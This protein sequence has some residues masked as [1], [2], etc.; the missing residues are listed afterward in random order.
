[1]FSSSIAHIR[2]L[3]II[4]YDTFLFTRTPFLWQVVQWLLHIKI[5]IIYTY[6][7]HTHTHIDIHCVGENKPSFFEFFFLTDFR[8][9]KLKPCW[10]SKRVSERYA[11]KSYRFSLLFSYEIR[12]KQNGFM[13]R[14][15][16]YGCKLKSTLKNQKEQYNYAS[17][18]LAENRIFELH[19]LQHTRA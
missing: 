18:D 5:I 6:S 12:S 7:V 1:M 17:S 14:K 13:V 10:I 2:V 19:Y 4:A 11:E 9:S 3:R 8:V 16:Y 15:T